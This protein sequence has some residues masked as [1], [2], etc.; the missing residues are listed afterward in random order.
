MIPKS[1]TI[2]NE[3]LRTLLESNVAALLKELHRLQV[4]SSLSLVGQLVFES[5]VDWRTGVYEQV[6]LDVLPRE[7]SDA[8]TN[9]YDLIQEAKDRK[10][11]I[12]YQ[13]GNATCLKLTLEVY[14]RITKGDK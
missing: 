8:E 14:R 12:A 2:K 7:V 6:I 1:R 11:I 5:S 4:K 3:E 13:W 10:E 9:Y